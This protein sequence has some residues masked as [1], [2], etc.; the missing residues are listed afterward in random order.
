MSYH[1]FNNQSN[2][3]DFDYDYE[4]DDN[5]E[6]YGTYEDLCMVNCTPVNDDYNY[7]NLWTSGCID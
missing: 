1:K 4:I 7:L 5:I 2:E 3:D 6:Y